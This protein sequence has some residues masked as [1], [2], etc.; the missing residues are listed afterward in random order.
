MALE[1]QESQEPQD[2]GNINLP[3]LIIWMK[4]E[5]YEATTIRRV[6]KE[7][8]HVIRNC[9][10]RSP[11]AVKL[12][13]A[14]KKCGNG[15]KENLIEAYDKVMQSLGLY[16]K[17]PFYQRK[18]KKRR[19]PKEELLNFIIDNVNFPLNLKLSMHKDL[20]NRPIELTWLKVKDVDLTT[21]ATSLT[22][23]KHTVGREGKL[24]PKS[25]ELL[26]R[27]ISRDNLNADSTIF[28]TTSE[29]LS[30]EYRH[31]RNNLAKVTNRPELK[32]VQLY[33]FRRFKG[34]RTYHLSGGKILEVAHVLGHKEHDLRATIQYIDTE[35]CI[36]WIPVKCKTDEE[37][38]QAIKD[39]C[40]LVGHE[41]G[42]W[43][44]KK[45]A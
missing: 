2:I 39:D 22:G 44:F 23:A 25:L 38:Q 28:P 7:L 14:N 26:K 3:N 45:P 30:Q 8:K 5:A 33:D 43:Y 19:A 36:T 16:W 29:N 35:A 4:K 32:Q 18:R 31:A 1:S 17:K 15:R 11:E 24:K 13:I 40:V 10:S 21:G 41:N 27:L 42:V 34:T 12:F 9:D 6:V 20:G 37:I